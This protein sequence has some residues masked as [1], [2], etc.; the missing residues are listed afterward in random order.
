MLRPAVECQFE[1]D[2]RGSE[3][4]HT[5]AEDVDLLNRVRLGTCNALIG[6]LL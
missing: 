4:G 2:N 1:K 6:Q 3:N 5:F